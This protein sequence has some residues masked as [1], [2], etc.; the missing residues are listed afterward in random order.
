L[1]KRERLSSTY[2]PVGRLM[3]LSLS[4]KNAQRQ[5]VDAFTYTHDK[6]GNR[7]TKA[8]DD[9][10]YTYSYDAVYRLL[11]ALPTKKSKV[12][13]EQAEDYSYDPVGNRLKGP[14][15]TDQQYTYNK[16]NQLTTDRNH[17]YQY[18][19]NGNLIRKVDWDEDGKKKTHSYFYDY[20]NRLMR[21]EIQKGRKAKE[22]TFTYDPFG[23]RISKS[24]HRDEIGDDED[25][26][27]EDRERPRTTQYVYDNE[28]ILMEFNHKGSRI[29]QPYTFTGREWDSETKLYYYRARYYD[30]IAGMFTQK[31]PIGFS[32][33]DVNLYRMVENNP[34]NWVDPWGLCP[35]GTHEATPD[36]AT[37]ILSA[38]KDIAKKNLSYKDV[39]CNQFVDRSINQAF[40][41]ALQKEYNTNEIRQGQGPFENTD[42]PAVGELALFNTPG[43]VVLISGMRNNKVSQFLG[44]QT[45]TG[46]STVNLPDYF[47]Q[48]RLDT[49]GNVQYYKIC[50]PN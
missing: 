34:V 4:A 49:K 3:N 23:R 38:A 26:D 24:V 27:G 29:K 2:D 11:Q 35:T 42:L 46:P 47:W 41:D 14:K 44:S 9:I 28:D 8:D 31:D 15:Q 16:D 39:K 13:K 17:Q 20:E 1:E 32:G 5:V 10:K 37:K 48:G 6:I 12:Q 45:S 30:P 18:D 40:P 21:V 50:L 25:G 43:H 7:I 36:E 33:G 19:A 22:V